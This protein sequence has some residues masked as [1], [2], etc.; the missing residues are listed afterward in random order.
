MLGALL[1]SLTGKLVGSV[2]QDTLGASAAA[3]ADELARYERYAFSRLDEEF[4]ALIGQ[5]DA[6][7]GNLE[8]LTEKAFDQHANTALRLAS[9]VRI[10]VPD[11][12]IL[13]T[14]DDLDA[15]MQE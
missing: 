15:F 10:G 8:R 1:G 7:F 12:K 5:L 9:S 3:L 4:R 6:W 14:T 13:R 11:A 2:L